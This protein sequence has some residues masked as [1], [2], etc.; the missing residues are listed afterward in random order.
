MP[1]LNRGQEELSTVVPLVRHEVGEHV[2]DVERK[3]APYIS[4]RGRKVPS[5][6]QAACQERFDSS[7][8]LREGDRKLATRSRATVDG[9]GSG[10]A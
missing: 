9:I 1:E 4:L 8:T 6:G 5:F 3:V 10:D 2:R 7:P